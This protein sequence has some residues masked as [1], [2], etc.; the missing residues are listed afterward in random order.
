MNDRPRLLIVGGYGT[1]GGRIVQLL[2][3]EARLTLIVAGRSLK[4][5]SDYCATR[6]AARAE[7]IAAM[8]DRDG[9]LAG[10]LLM[11]RPDIL[12]DASGPFQ[13][14]GEDRYRVIEA[15]IAHGVNYLDLA[16]G[17]DFVLGVDA[18]DQAARA[19]GLFALSGLSSFPVLTAAAV[20]RLSLGM[21]RVDAIRAGLAPSPHVVLGENVIRAMASYAGQ[22]IR[23]TS[24]RLIATGHPFTEHM[25]FT[26]APPGRLP[27]GNRLFSLVDVP[28]LRILPGLWP[29]AR[30][31]WIGAGPVPEMLHRLLIAAAW[32]VRLRIIASLSP[33]ASLMHFA[34]KHLRWGEH[35]SGMFVAIEG[36]DAADVPARRSWHLL[37]EGDEGPLIPAMAVAAI[38]RKVLDGHSPP[39]GARAA[40]GDVDLDDYERLFAGR[41]I[42]MGTRNDAPAGV[43]PLYKRILGLAFDDLPDEIRAMHDV[44]GIAVAEGRARVDRG[45]SLLARL[46]AAVIGFPAAAADTPVS[47]TF[48]QAHGE[49][50]WRRTFGRDTFAS[51]QFAG[52]GRFAGL[53]CERFGILTFAMALVAEEGRLALV[54]RRWSAFGIPLPM[55][56]C[57]RSHSYE[58]VEEGRFRFHVEIG[59]P[60]TGLIV[61]YRGWLVPRA[62]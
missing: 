55:W 25:R 10:Q 62:G 14:Y 22:S 59:H 49:E 36:I 5:A 12:V 60:L 24:D 18:F 53:L 11:L 52:R 15:C 2:E 32:L 31:V 4:R 23:L 29:E 6:S 17:S 61:R 13:A 9:D 34:M 57:P 42:H 8:F 27:L 19:A 1:F 38:V 54:L 45:G 7:L 21:V 3:T 30:T 51:R 39:P 16:D 41:R 40:V 50:T 28:D 20:R 47:V 48:T 26:I 37:A 33:L 44:D 43:V 58:T 35:R 56:L 46:A